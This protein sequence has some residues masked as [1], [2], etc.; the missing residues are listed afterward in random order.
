M[1][2]KKQKPMM[3]VIPPPPPQEIPEELEVCESVNGRVV[4]RR[5]VE[6]R[7]VLA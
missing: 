6:K 5:R 7:K 3:I 2:K 4:C 1:I